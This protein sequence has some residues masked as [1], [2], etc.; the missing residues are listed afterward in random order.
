MTATT[1]PRA[2]NQLARFYR[3]KSNGARVLLAK[4]ATGARGIARAR[5][6]APSHK[7]YRV[8]VKVSAPPG[9]LPGKSKIG[10]IRIR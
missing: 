9:N 7:R 10:A 4:V 1:L 3:V 6:S 2:A 5:I 8:I